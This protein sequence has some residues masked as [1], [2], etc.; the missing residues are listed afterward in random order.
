MNI[1]IPPW[2][3]PEIADW[4]YETTE[5]LSDERTTDDPPG[6]TEDIVSA[7]RE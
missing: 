5:S 3:A 2:G 7:F 6:G 1:E 4:L